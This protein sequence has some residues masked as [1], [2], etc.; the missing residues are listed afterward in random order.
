MTRRMPL[1]RGL[2]IAGVLALALTG[3]AGNGADVYG[4]WGEKA[5]AK[6]Y[7]ELSDDGSVAGS[8]GCNRMTGNFTVDGDTVTFGQ[9]ASTLMACEGV[10]TW[11]SK[12]ETATVDGDTMTVFNTKGDEIGTLDRAE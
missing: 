5:N 11:L 7:L 6:P 1:G 2:A 8:D 3:C 4:T 9:L 10:D 12:A